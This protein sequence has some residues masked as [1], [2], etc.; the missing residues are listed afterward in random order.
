MNDER[1]R[2]L[3]MLS[4]G[5]INIE[6]ASQLLEASLKSEKEISLIQA[7]SEN[8]CMLMLNRKRQ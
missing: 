1:T 6:E 8:L 2:I 7:K 5:K 3:E 4:Q